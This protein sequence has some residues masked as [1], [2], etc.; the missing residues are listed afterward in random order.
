VVCLVA[1]PALCFCTFTQLFIQS[2]SYIYKYKSQSTYTDH[3]TQVCM[4][5]CTPALAP[6]SLRTTHQPLQQPVLKHKACLCNRAPKLAR[7][8]T[9]LP[10]TH[11]WCRDMQSVPRQ[12]CPHLLNAQAMRMLQCA[13]VTVCCCTH[14]T[15]AVCTHVPGC[16]HLTQDV[17]APMHW[18]CLPRGGCQ[19]SL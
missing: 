13:H 12:S 19:L 5:T 4:V 18:V 15:L 17:L 11:C 6:V 14:V 8:N 2:T 10:H 1:S 9:P 7:G 16:L 3:N